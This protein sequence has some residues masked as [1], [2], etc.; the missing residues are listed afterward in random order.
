MSEMMGKLNTILADSVILDL[1]LGIAALG[2]D[3]ETLMGVTSDEMR[4]ENFAS[5]C[6]GGNLRVV[7]EERLR[8]GYFHGLDASLWTRHRETRKVSLSEMA[9]SIPGPR[10][11]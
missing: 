2:R 7:L 8:S 5:I 3:V 4:G 9:A 10:S 1:G 11:P 6:V